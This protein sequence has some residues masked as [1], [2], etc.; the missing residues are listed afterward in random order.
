MSVRKCILLVTA[1]LDSIKF[2]NASVLKLHWDAL[3][4]K[5]RGPDAF[6]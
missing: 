4:P 5:E 2:V 6:G 1:K 3:M